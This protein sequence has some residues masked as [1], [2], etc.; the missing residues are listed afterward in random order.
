MVSGENVN[1]RKAGVGSFV[2]FWVVEGR[3]SDGIFQR[4]DRQVPWKPGLYM[5]VDPGITIIVPLEK[6]LRCW[7]LSF[8]FTV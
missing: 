3:V 4:F 2:D 5:C 8:L 7:A 1:W 6:I